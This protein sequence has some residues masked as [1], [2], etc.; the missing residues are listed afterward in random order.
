MGGKRRE[1]CD[2]LFKEV[3]IVIVILK[4]ARIS[5][6][7]E[8]SSIRLVVRVLTTPPM[9]RGESPRR[10]AFLGAKRKRFLVL[11]PECPFN[12]AFHRKQQQDVAVNIFG[13]TKQ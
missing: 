12:N 1:K 9:S 3:S 11:W 6:L 7:I 2:L 8:P 5:T 4:K 13:R 10:K